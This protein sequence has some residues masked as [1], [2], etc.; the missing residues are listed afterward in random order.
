[1]KDK[2]Q[3]CLQYGDL[4]MIEFFK[5]PYLFILFSS[6][7]PGL[8]QLPLL[9]GSLQL[10]VLYLMLQFLH[11]QKSTTTVQFCIGNSAAS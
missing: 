3:V 4:K 11:L 10:I 9:P 2:M 7:L 5:S 8:Q 1:M 6:S